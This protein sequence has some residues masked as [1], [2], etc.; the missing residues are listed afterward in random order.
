MPRMFQCI[1][2]NVEFRVGLD[3]ERDFYLNADQ[4]A[5]FGGSRCVYCYNKKHPKYP[6]NPMYCYETADRFA[7]EDSIKEVVDTLYIPENCKHEW[8]TGAE[9]QL[10]LRFLDVPE[11]TVRELRLLMKVDGLNCG[12]VHRG[13][14]QTYAFSVDFSTNK[15]KFTR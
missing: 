6:L 9:Y 3:V 5:S 13:A 11:A 1:D 4:N 7:H 10:M 2:C 12:E 14:N 15:R 8:Y